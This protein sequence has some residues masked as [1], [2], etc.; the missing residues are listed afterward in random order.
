MAAHRPIPSI[1][2][3]GSEDRQALS[4]V[5]QCLDVAAAHRAAIE[6]HQQQIIFIHRE[7]NQ[8]R[9]VNTLPQE[10]LVD[11]FILYADT[12]AQDLAHKYTTSDSPEFP[13]T[14]DIPYQWVDVSHVCHSWRCVS[15]PTPR[16][17]RYIIVNR[18]YM[19]MECI[20]RSQDMSLMVWRFGNSWLDTAQ[21]EVLR[22]VFPQL[23]R[24]CD[25]RIAT[26][27]ESFTWLPRNED[28]VLSAPLLTTL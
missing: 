20:A 2:N 12:H 27:D 14:G 7:L 28:V 22:A 17:W 24:I 11:I 15:L 5:Q 13:S 10:L 8:L 21:K 9:P 6:A 25:L 26:F 3:V 16:L 4:P 18:P 1:R 19:A 23:S